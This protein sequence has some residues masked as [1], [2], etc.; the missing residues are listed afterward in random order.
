MKTSEMTPQQLAEACSEALH[1]SDQAAQAMG[2]TI[3][4][5]APG[6]AKLSVPVRKDMLNGHAISHGGCMFTLCDTAFRSEERRVGKE[7]R[8]PVTQYNEKRTRHDT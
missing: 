6:Y 8:L 3:E 4:E 5:I 2:M 1:S 7:W